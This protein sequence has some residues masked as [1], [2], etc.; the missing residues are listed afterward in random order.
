MTTLPLARAGGDW[1]DPH[2]SPGDQFSCPVHSWSTG[3]DLAGD[4]LK[5]RYLLDP[6]SPTQWGERGAQ[7]RPG[8]I[9]GD[10]SSLELG[11]PAR[12]Q[13]V[14]TELGCC[15]QLVPVPSTPLLAGGWRRAGV[16]GL[17]P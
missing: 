12:E 9:L 2:L 14:P 6:H 7:H 15:W 11:C 8:A 1:W 17:W 13:G 4:V 16:A 3:E 10:P 5:H